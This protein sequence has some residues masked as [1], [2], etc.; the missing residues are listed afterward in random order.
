MTDWL[1]PPYYEP[2]PANPEFFMNGP[3]LDVRE[4]IEY[5]MGLAILPGL[6][7][8]NELFNNNPA[9]DAMYHDPVAYA[10]SLMAEAADLQQKGRYY[11][12][13]GWTPTAAALKYANICFGILKQI[14]CN[15]G[16]PD[17]NNLL[18]SWVAGTGQFPGGNAPHAAQPPDT[19]LHPETGQSAAPAGTIL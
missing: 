19:G 18:D 16:M 1:N 4:D 7:G 14:P 8:P 11:M 3:F 10:K 17:T 9:L 6:Q 13:E 2:P 5:G 12:P 15:R